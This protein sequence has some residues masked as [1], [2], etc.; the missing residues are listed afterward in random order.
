M[1]EGNK[2]LDVASVVSDSLKES[3]LLAGHF[4]SLSDAFSQAEAADETRRDNQPEH[5]TPIGSMNTALVN[6]QTAQ[7]SDLIA[8]T[9]L[10]RFY[11]KWSMIGLAAQLLVMN[12]VF[13]GVGVQCLQ[14]SDYILHLYMAGTLAECFG[15]VFVITRYLF[16]KHH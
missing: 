5:L 4:P 3:G 6:H 14:F 16:S 9:A 12:L 8:E 1:A 10:K 7:T 11:A 2:P 15:V 13:I